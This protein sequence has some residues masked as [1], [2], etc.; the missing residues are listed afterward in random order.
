MT[1]DDKNYISSDAIMTRIKEYEAKDPKGLNGF[2][3]LMH[4][5]AGPRRTDKFYERADELIGWLRSRNYELVRVDE[6]L[7]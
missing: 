1:D 4:I 7:R 5:G 2:I 6:L 3:L